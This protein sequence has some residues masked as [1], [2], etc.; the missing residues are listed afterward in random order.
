VHE[1][2]RLD[3][4][5]VRLEPDHP[6]EKR[7]RMSRPTCCLKIPPSGGVKVWPHVQTRREL[8]ALLD[9]LDL[10]P[11]LLEA[12]RPADDMPSEFAACLNALGSY[13]TERFVLRLSPRVH[14]LVDEAPK[15]IYSTDTLNAETIQ[16][17]TTVDVL[18]LRQP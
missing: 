17:Y 13:C 2:K 3:E 7:R 18:A 11:A 9:H 1:S 10:N 16:A 6:E 5:I 4:I 12:E 8:K 15:G 14:R